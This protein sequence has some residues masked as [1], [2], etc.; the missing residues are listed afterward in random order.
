VP[1]PF[2]QSEQW[3]QKSVSESQPN[4]LVCHRTG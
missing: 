3:L 2:C 4:L 1:L